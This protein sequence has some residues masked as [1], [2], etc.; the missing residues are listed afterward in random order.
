MVWGNERNEEVWQINTSFPFASIAACL[1]DEHHFTYDWEDKSTSVHWRAPPAQIIWPRAQSPVVKQE[2][3]L[4][5]HI[6]F[7]LTV[8]YADLQILHSG[9]EQQWGLDLSRI[10]ISSV[11]CSWQKDGGREQKAKL[12]VKND[13]IFSSKWMQMFT[14]LCG[15]VNQT[16]KDKEMFSLSCGFLYMYEHI[17]YI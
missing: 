6:P 13:I 10:L 7:C 8:Y 14:V 5:A 17:I 3:T 2:S 15:Q 11:S 12:R 1:F 4:P 9:A 16:H